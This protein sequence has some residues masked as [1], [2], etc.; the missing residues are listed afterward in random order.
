MCRD[1]LKLSTKQLYRGISCVEFDRGN[2]VELSRKKKIGTTV[3]G[4]VRPLSLDYH[5]P[6]TMVST[7]SLNDFVY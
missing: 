4:T 1:I 7:Y 3:S 6:E 2:I 5:F